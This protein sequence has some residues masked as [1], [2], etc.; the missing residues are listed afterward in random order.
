MAEPVPLTVGLPPP[1]DRAF[2]DVWSALG[3]ELKPSLD[4]V[5]V[6]PVDTG[7]V[8]PVGP[9]VLTPPL[10]RVGRQGD[11]EVETFTRRTSVDLAPVPSQPPSEDG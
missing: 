3:G 7:Q 10:I 11:D 8:R 2:A 5:V 6:V 4:V 9:P 1:E